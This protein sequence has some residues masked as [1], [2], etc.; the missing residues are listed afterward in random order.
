MDFYQK[1]NLALFGIIHMK[2][3]R[4]TRQFN[5]FSFHIVLLE[6][7]EMFGIV[8]NI[9]LEL[10]MNLFILTTCRLVTYYSCAF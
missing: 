10:T 7:T 6:H 3:M 5:A 8:N 2:K 4:D 9:F 1:T